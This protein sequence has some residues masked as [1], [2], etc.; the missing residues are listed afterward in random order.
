MSSVLDEADLG[1]VPDESRLNLA[2]E[3]TLGAEQNGSRGSSSSENKSSLEDVE[4]EDDEEQIDRLNSSQG[5]KG[6]VEDEG[7]PG[8]VGEEQVQDKANRRP[9]SADG[10][11]SIP[12][13]APSVQVRIISLPW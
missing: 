1:P 5:E 3:E 2:Q 7:E 11:L 8:A 12:D 6:N 10:S 13:D 9:S 4:R